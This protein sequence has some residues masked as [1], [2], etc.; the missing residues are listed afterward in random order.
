VEQLGQTGAETLM[1]RLGGIYTLEQIARDSPEYRRPIW[2]LLTAYI[3]Q[4]VPWRESDAREAHEALSEQ[5]SGTII[6]L[7]APK[8]RADIQA[9]VMMLGNRDMWNVGQYERVDYDLHGTN[10]QGV[11]LAGAHLRGVDLS[12]AYLEGAHLNHADLAYADL[13]RAQC[14]GADLHSANL[15][16]AW[17]RNAYLIEA[18]L[19]NADLR[20]AHL[21]HANLYKACLEYADLREAHLEH[22]LLSEAS[23][24]GANLQ[25]AHLE[26]ARLVRSVGLTQAQLATAITDAKTQLP[27]GLQEGS[28]DDPRSAT[29][30]D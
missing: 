9:I 14:Y 10:L 26:G 5:P 19:G 23:L 16:E 18:E 22:A 29:D 21:E 3:R 8:P 28:I 17:L 30:A 2:E 6:A 20:E 12:G 25:G 1:I 27:A 4:Q 7:P 13:A 15:R 11:D 24:E